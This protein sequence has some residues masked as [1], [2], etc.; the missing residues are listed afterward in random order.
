MEIRLNKYLSEAGV[1]SRREADRLIESGKVTVDGK[2][3]EM[4]MKIS[5]LLR[6]LQS[7][8]SHMAII[9]DEFGGTVGI[10]TL[11]DIIEELV[12]EIWDEHDEVIENIKQFDSVRC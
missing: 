4:G 12:G 2:R 6:T 7:R 9:L 5:E 3:A 8:K 10:V 11:E 1:C